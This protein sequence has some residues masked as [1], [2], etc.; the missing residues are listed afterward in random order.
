MAGRPLRR[1]RRARYNPTQASSRRAKVRRTA[2]GGDA[3]RKSTA[4][5]PRYFGHGPGQSWELEQDGIRYVLLLHPVRDILMTAAGRAR[6]K[7]DNPNFTLQAQGEDKV[8]VHLGGFA[9][10]KKALQF[11]HRE[12]GREYRHGRHAGQWP[13]RVGK[14]YL[15]SVG[16]M[17]AS[18]DSQPPTTAAWTGYGL[19]VHKKEHEGDEWDIFT[20]SAVWGFDSRKD[21]LDAVARWDEIQAR[22]LPPEA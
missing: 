14:E 8:W 10:K 22:L 1:A 3:W 6:G 7:Y 9:S 21:A 20:G 18:Y 11:L 12:G 4:Q 2:R 5:G 15:N 13:L 17:S 19:V 16:P